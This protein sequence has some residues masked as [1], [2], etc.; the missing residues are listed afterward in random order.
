MGEGDAVVGFNHGLQG[1]GGL[2]QMQQGHAFVDSRVSGR[3]QGLGT[4]SCVHG[5]RGRV[6][7]GGVVVCSRAAWSGQWQA[8]SEADLV[9][10]DGE[11]VRVP[12]CVRE[13][14]AMDCRVRGGEEVTGR[15]TQCMA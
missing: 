12:G 13:T 8:R 15:S 6:F 10:D 14:S 2:D 9:E 3:G 11:E 5:R 4:G 1:Q 7:M